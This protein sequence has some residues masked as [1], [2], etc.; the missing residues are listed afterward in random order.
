MKNT[1]HIIPV[2]LSVV[3]VIICGCAVSGK[4]TDFNKKTT[5]V[6]SIYLDDPGTL[7]VHDGNSMR[8]LLLTK[9][10]VVRI[11]A[12]DSKMLN[13]ELYY[14][15][16]IVFMDGTTIGS[17]DEKR[18]KAYVAVNHRLFGYAQGSD[19]SIMLNDISKIE[20]GIR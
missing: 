5:F 2:I 1:M 20:F 15:A 6:S 3:S 13:R 18:V 7:K 8:E 19:Y 16:E 14:L 17:F 11:S 4:V 12:D 9:I 10:K